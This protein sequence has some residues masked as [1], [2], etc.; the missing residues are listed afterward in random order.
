MA[1]ALDRSFKLYQNDS[2]NELGTLHSVRVPAKIVRQEKRFVA[3]ER[4]LEKVHRSG[5]KFKLG[6]TS[7]V[8]MFTKDSRTNF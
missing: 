6:M 2:D 1:K 4:F 5:F 7:D 3:N 8:L